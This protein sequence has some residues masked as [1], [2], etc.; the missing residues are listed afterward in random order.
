MFVVGKKCNLVYNLFYRPLHIFVA[1][2]FKKI[3]KN[4]LDWKIVILYF[5]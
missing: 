1:T 4:T 2:A 3:L 5:N